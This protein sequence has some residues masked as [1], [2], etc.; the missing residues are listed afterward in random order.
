MVRESLWHHFSSPQFW[1]PTGHVLSHYLPVVQFEKIGMEAVQT[2]WLLQ[3]ALLTARRRKHNLTISIAM[4]SAAA[5][6]ERDAAEG[7]AVAH[8]PGMDDRITFSFFLFQF[9]ARR[10]N[11]AEC[12]N[13]RAN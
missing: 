12:R 3:L 8:V 11:D 4:S 1:A 10:K 9:W 5:G 2:A 13:R 6:M 7:A